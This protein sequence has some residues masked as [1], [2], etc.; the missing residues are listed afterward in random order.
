[1]S[2]LSLEHSTFAYRLDFAVYTAI[3][4]ASAAA[5][6][7]A[8]PDGTGWVLLVW[9]A[10]GSA[11]W[12]LLEYLLHRYVLHGVAPFSDW[13]GQHHL[14]P[15]ALI[16]SPIVLSLSLFALLAA[17]P[18]WL[19]LGSWTALALTLGLMVSYLGYGLVHH[20]THHKTPPWI[21]QNAWLS[22]RRICHAMHHAAYH[23]QA[24]GE[25]CIPC[26][27]GVSSGVW[28]LLLG[29]NALR[30]PVQKD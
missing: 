5:L 21:R 11:L 20:A 2:L 12:S 23:I 25:P 14:R 26:H 24:R 13:H 29:S 6:L 17:L 8:S 30:R 3:C 4:C 9:V 15:Q 18:A 7:L 28:D 16:S 22:E 27:F 10:A 19:L 1:M